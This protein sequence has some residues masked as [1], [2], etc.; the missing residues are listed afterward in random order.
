MNDGIVFS[1]SVHNGVFCIAKSH[2]KMRQKPYRALSV[3]PGGLP[4]NTDSRTIAKSF[5]V[6]RNALRAIQEEAKRQNLSVNT[7]VN[8]LLIS[9]ADFGR[10]AQRAHSLNLTQKTFAEILA[11]CSPEMLATAGR[12]AGRSGPLAMISSKSGDVTV[13]A[14]L[15]YIQDLSA[16]GNLFEF[17]ETNEHGHWTITLLHELGSNW[18]IF[19]EN[20][21]A[22]AF[23]AAAAEPKITSSERA[24]MIRI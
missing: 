5:R 7:M 3:L 1:E 8:Q 24:V 23:K 4:I 6:N 15:E 20:Y 19:L 14:V 9:Y 2:I 18:S 11:A 13:N 10:F 16:H 12:N 22:E 17:N 21:F